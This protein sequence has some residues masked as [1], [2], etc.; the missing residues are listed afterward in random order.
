MFKILQINTVLSLK[1]K[2]MKIVEERP[3]DT[4]PFAEYQ[5]YEVLNPNMRQKSYNVQ[6]YQQKG[7]GWLNSKI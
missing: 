2:S 1:V 3:V 5:R 6:L 4:R 7:L